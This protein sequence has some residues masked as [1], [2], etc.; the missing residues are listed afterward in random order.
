[1]SKLKEL[2]GIPED[3]KLDADALYKQATSG[4]INIERP[5]VMDMK[6]KAEWE[7]WNK[8]KGMSKEDAM[9]E[10]VKLTKE[11]MK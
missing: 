11:Y 3:R 2:K 10:Y 8:R 1:M 6:G 4:D 5:G 7:A 9:K